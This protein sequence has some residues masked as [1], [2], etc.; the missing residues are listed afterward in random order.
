MFQSAPV[1]ASYVANALEAGNVWTRIERFFLSAVE[2]DPGIEAI[3]VQ[4][5]GRLGGLV[6]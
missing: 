2:A 3:R 4:V 6:V 5:K 1:V